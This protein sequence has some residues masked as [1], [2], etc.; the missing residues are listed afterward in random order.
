MTLDGGEGY[1][2]TRLVLYEYLPPIPLYGGIIPPTP[3][4]PYVSPL[5]IG[6]G[7]PQKGGI[8]PKLMY[9]FKKWFLEFLGKIPLLYTGPLNR[10][11]NFWK[12]FGIYG[13]RIY[14]EKN[15]GH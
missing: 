6:E 5:Y 9:T 12:I 10:K 8:I 11:K 15:Y 7:S 4:P 14:Y 3:P 13:K 2:M 1:V